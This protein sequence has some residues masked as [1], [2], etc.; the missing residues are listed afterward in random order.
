MSGWVGEGCKRKRIDGLA[1]VFSILL[2]HMAAGAHSA[3]SGDDES[4]DL[5]GGGPH[6]RKGHP[7]E[8]AGRGCS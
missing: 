8:A 2:G 1:E 7:K 5:H 3:A 6:L 4:C